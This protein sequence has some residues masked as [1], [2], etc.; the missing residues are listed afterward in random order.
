MFVQFRET[1]ILKFL[2]A[3]YGTSLHNDWCKYR[4]ILDRGEMSVIWR[5]K[6]DHNV[7]IGT[8]S[9]L[10]QVLLSAS[11]DAITCEKRHENVLYLCVQTKWWA[12]CRYIS[13][14]DKLGMNWRII[15]EPEW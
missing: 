7:N 3:R 10:E 1:L 14:T 5:K 9:N 12:A 11:I 2:Q 4:H 13:Y 15:I 6:M 8:N